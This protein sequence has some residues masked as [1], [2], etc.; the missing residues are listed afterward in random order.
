MRTSKRTP[1]EKRKAVSQ[2]VTRWRQNAKRKL[3]EYKGGKCII[4]NYNRCIQ[5]LVFHHR[6]PSQKEFA[7][8][9]ASKSFEK[10]KIEADKCELLCCLCHGEVHA[11]LVFIP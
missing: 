9:A 1:E 2:K 7:I 10:M 6:D 11:G 4:C 5:N 3:V 8:T